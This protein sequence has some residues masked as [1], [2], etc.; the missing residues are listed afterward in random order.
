MSEVSTSENRNTSEDDPEHDWLLEMLVQVANDAGGKFNIT[1]SV[2]GTLI[3]GT[4]I[5][6][7]EYFES[8]ANQYSSLFTG[9]L[10]TNVRQ[11]YIGFGRQY[12]AENRDGTPLPP[13]AYLHLSDARFFDSAGNSIPSDVGATWRG[14]L[15]SVDGFFLG[16]LEKGPPK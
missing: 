4:L 5:G 1:I 8:F 9:E 12:L 16:R 6:G 14:R 10:A 15:S 7:A 11:H 2:G 3:S 13:A